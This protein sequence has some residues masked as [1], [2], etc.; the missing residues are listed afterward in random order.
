M[1]SRWLDGD[2]GQSAWSWSRTQWETSTSWTPSWEAGWWNGDTPWDQS[3]DWDQSDEWE[4]ISTWAN[5]VVDENHTSEDEG[6]DTYTSRPTS[7]TTS[8]TSTSRPRM[9]T[10]TSRRP[11]STSTTSTST[12]SLWDPAWVRS[13]VNSLVTGVVL[14]ATPF[15]NAW[16]D[17]WIL[18]L[19]SSTTTSAPEHL[20]P[21][22]HGLFPE[23]R[24]AR[25]GLE[26]DETGLMR[27]TNSEMALL[28]ESGASR[29]HVRRVA[30]LLE[31]LDEA[32]VQGQGPEARWS[33]ARLLRRVVEAQSTINVTVRVLNRRLR[34]RG[35]LPVQR[36]PR[37]E[38]ERWRRFMWGRQFAGIFR[39]CLENSMMTP[40][41]PGEDDGLVGNSGTSSE[42]SPAHQPASPPSTVRAAARNRSRSPSRSREQDADSDYALDSE[43]ELVHVPDANLDTQNGPPV[44]LPVN[45]ISLE[46]VGIWRDPEEE[47]AG[48]P[49]GTE[50]TTSTTTSTSDLAP[51]VTVMTTSG[52][53]SS[54][55]STSTCGITSMFTVSPSCPTTPTSM[56]STSASASVAST[57][58]T[59]TLTLTTSTP[60]IDGGVL[61][62][63]GYTWGEFYHNA[64][65]TSPVTSCYVPGV[66]ATTWIPVGW[67][68]T[69]TTTS[70]T[71]TTSGQSGA[72][73]PSDIVRDAVNT[74]LV[75][76]GP[77]DVI[78]FI[79]LALARQRRLRHMDRL[80]GEA[81]VEA[82]NWLQIPLSAEAMNARTYDARIWEVV[83]RE[84]RFGSGT[85]R[86]TPSQLVTMQSAL[87]QNSLPTSMEELRAM[88]PGV[89]ERALRGYRRRAWRENARR[90]HYDGGR[91]PREP[92]DPLAGNSTP[93]ADH[94]QDLLLIQRDDHQW[95]ENWPDE[96]PRPPHPVRDR[97]GSAAG[98]GRRRLRFRRPRPR[99][100]EP[101][102]D[103]SL[104]LTI[105]MVGE[106]TEIGAGME[107]GDRAVRRRAARRRGA[108]GFERDPG[109][110]LLRGA[111]EHRD[112]ERGRERSRSRDTGP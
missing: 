111:R 104:A 22:N 56:T 55:T 30:D 60:P 86:S 105:P 101:G 98:G 14:A 109:P 25:L 24:P 88:V 43:G 15:P 4:G 87:L 79:H 73:W 49:D 91:E 99:W 67:A 38:T 40:P 19:T 17:V 3:N 51:L 96:E 23:V 21:P 57:T 74:H 34:P 35:V 65:V 8:T 84:A 12:F 42:A 106:D 52:W 76:G 90:L 112:R 5:N 59:L 89:S 48:R 78:Q 54:L 10:T 110:G 94:D 46:P 33:L 63:Q 26:A 70:T 41:Q 58:P 66:V 95:V 80:L 93:G 47:D 29:H 72:T 45:L 2:W 18:T 100:M 39:D 83:V 103:P 31:S 108:A 69:S 81:V 97:P 77:A 85:T 16:G 32:Q 71:T 6:S 92:R 37:G 61:A 68:R 50:D 53:M 64:S 13:G 9:C 82:L 44:P 28:Q 62:S 102:E 7:S 36:V 1:T 75:H 107:I 11:T 20:H 27:I